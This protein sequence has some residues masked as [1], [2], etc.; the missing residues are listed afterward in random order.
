[1]GSIVLEP[2]GRSD[3]I[4]LKQLSWCEPVPFEENTPDMPAPK[5][6]PNVP[7]EEPADVAA[8]FEESPQKRVQTGTARGKLNL[9]YPKGQELKSRIGDVCQDGTQ[10]DAQNL[11]HSELTKPQTKVWLY[12]QHE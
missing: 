8:P 6:E 2:D 3:F 12:T 1:M 10:L 5:P 11:E 9:H 7:P 4:M